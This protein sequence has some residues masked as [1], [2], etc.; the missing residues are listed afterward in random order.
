MF[1]VA[2]TT[3]LVSCGSF[4]SSLSTSALVM[5]PSPTDIIIPSLSYTPFEI[6]PSLTPT[7]EIPTATSTPTCDASLNFCISDGHFFFH[8]PFFLPYRMTPEMSY[9]FGETEDGHLEPHHGIDIPNATGTPVAAA[10]DGTVVLADSDRK[11]LVGPYTDFYGN[12]IV[13]QHSLD[14]IQQPVYSLYGHLSEIS[15]V[16]GQAVQAG[17]EIG[18]VG[19]T[20]IAMGSHLHFEVRLGENTYDAS[21]NPYLWLIPLDGTGVIA[22]RV[23]DEQGNMLHLT[24]IKIQ[25][26][27]SDTS[28]PNSTLTVETY[29]PEKDHVISDPSL[30]ENFAVGDLTAGRYKISFDADYQLYQRWVDVDAGKLTYVEFVVK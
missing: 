23:V 22:G 9:L 3:L 5:K 16:A 24:N 6:I 11:N 8:R 18:R 26:Y 20:G 12:V 14:G 10:A 7:S 25:Y 19:L 4:H 27:P 21:S 13:I 28:Q 15:V 30:Q 17:E 1:V 2:L 29:G